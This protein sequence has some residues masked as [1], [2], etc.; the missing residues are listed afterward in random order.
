MRNTLIAILASITFFRAFT[1]SES[2]AQQFRSPEVHADRSV[3]L[4]LHSKTAKVVSVAISGSDLDLTRGDHDIWTVTTKP[5]SAGIYDYSFDVDGTRMIDPSNRN[6]KKWFTLASMVE[7][8]GTP[9]LLTEF[10]EVPHGV[11]QRLI[12]PSTSVGQSRPVIVYTP[13]DY[14]ATTDKTYP[15]II[16]MHG[17]G[18]DEAGW[19]EVGR[20]HL[21]ADNLLAAEEIEPCIFAMPYGHPIPPP[22]GARP[23][24]YFVINNELY[25]RDITQDLLPFLE[26]KFSVRKDAAGRSLVGLSMGG[27]HAIDTGLKNIDSFSSI[28]AFSAA[29]PQADKEDLKTKYPAMFGQE[30]AANRLRNFWIP[31]GDKDFLLERNQKFVAILKEQGVQHEFSITGGDHEWKLWREYAAEFLRRVVPAK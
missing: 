15:L 21:I 8:P 25:E 30:P 3:T 29:A 7:I 31:I 14:S 9:P 12:Y 20:V 1:M 4:R 26:S 27:G 13:P 17:F 6:V 10:R 11:V 19:T 2:L 5:L 22:Y 18:D 24:D 28:G 23:D 16:L